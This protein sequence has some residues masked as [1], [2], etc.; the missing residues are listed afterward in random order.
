MATAYNNMGLVSSKTDELNNTIA[1]AYT[2]RGFLATVTNAL[3][4]VSYSEYDF[5]GRLI[6]SVTPE[7]YVS[8]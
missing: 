4:G 5:Q 2:A 3:S 7:N 6:C 1:Y 8:G